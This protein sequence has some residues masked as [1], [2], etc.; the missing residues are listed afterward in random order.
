MT[1]EDTHVGLSPTVLQVIEK[2]AE[3]LRTDEGIEGDAID[4]I[5]KLLRKGV[6]PKPDEINMA[7]FSPPQD[8]E[9]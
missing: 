7:L 2:F 6:V 1:N 8:G 5:E 9:I 4:R 3:A